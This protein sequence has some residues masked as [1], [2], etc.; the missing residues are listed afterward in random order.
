MGKGLLLAASNNKLTPLYLVSICDPF[1]LDVVFVRLGLLT[2]IFF[3]FSK[4]VKVLF[5]FPLNFFDA[6]VNKT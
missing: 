2:K 1:E 3:P 4:F 5:H 6:K